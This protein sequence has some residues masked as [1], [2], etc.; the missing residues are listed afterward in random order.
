MCVYLYTQ[1]ESWIRAGF[2]IAAIIIFIVATIGVFIWKFAYPPSVAVY[3]TDP[4]KSLIFQLF[5][6]LVNKDISQLT[7]PCSNPAIMREAGFQGYSDFVTFVWD[8]IGANNLKS[9]WFKDKMY[10]IFLDACAPHYCN[11]MEPQVDVDNAMDGFA[12]G[13]ILLLNALTIHSLLVKFC[14]QG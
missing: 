5:Q 8:T 6:K 3:E 11:Y 2:Y 4:S 12:V 1:E 13:G 9:D 7:C 14:I 10:D